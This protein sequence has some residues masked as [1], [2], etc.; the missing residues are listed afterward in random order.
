MKSIRSVSRFMIL[1]VNVQLFQNH[2]LERLSFF[3]WLAFA[4]LS[5]ISLTIFVWAYFCALCSF[6]LIYLFFHP[7]HCVL[8]NVA[9]I[10]RTI[11]NGVVSVLFSFNVMLVILGLYLSISALESACQNP[12]ESSWDFYWDRVWSTSIYQVGKK[13]H[14][15]YWIFLSVFKDRIHV[16]FM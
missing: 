1:P 12:Q 10:Y 13:W 6:P 15:Q 8:T 7:H 11:F 2:L 16:P 4:V 3:H 9:F 14:W 5:K